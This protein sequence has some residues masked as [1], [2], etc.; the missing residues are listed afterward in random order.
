MCLQPVSSDVSHVSETSVS[1]QNIKLKKMSW[2]YFRGQERV[3]RRTTFLNAGITFHTVG[4]RLVSLFSIKMQV[5]AH[6]SAQKHSKCL[7][8][9]GEVAQFKGFYVSKTRSV[10]F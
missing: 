1:L 10:D 2:F 6:K 7:F 4:G 9:W 8:C 3:R 5:Q